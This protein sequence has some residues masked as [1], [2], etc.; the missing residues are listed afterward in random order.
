[1]NGDIWT[2]RHTKKY[3]QCTSEEIK[4]YPHH[5]NLLHEASTYPSLVSKS[6]YEFSKKAGF[7]IQVPDNYD[8][9]TLNI[10]AID[11]RLLRLQGEKLPSVL[12]HGMGDSCFNNGMKSI[13]ART[14]QITESY[15]TCIPTAD[16]L[17]DDT[18]NGYFLNM[19]ASIE[20]FASRVKAD[21]A[22][23]NGFNA[24]GFSQGNNLIRGYIARHND[25]P[26]NTFI[27]V[28]G[29]NAGIGA[30]PYCI[31]SE[32]EDTIGNIVM[33]IKAQEASSTKLKSSKICD[34]LMEVA[35]RK[36]Y[37]EFSQQHSFQANY[38]RDPRPEEKENYRKICQ[39]A[40]LNNEGLFF[41]STLND[42]FARTN[43]FVWV[44]ATNDKVVWPPEGEQWGAPNP[45]DPFNDILPMKL[46]EWYKKDFFGLRAADEA[47]KNK[48]ESFAGNHLE[49]TLEDFDEWVRKYF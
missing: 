28:N 38:W 24:V 23:K 39:L 27:S 46:T 32:D 41:N 42:N 26:I 36:A 45:D 35:S 37:T 7:V 2:S 9:L 21:P 10:Q 20:E 12:S 8:N 5:C 31:P 1:V 6:L 16:N 47:G 49:F 4:S 25:P 11:R 30:L 33:S 17:H 43:K 14:S 44:M 15:A 48:F 22:L 19:D 34:A 18:I 29:V 3:H 13:T 40:T